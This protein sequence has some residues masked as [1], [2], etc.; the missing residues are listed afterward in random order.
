MGIAAIGLNLLLNSGLGAFRGHD[1]ECRCLDG[2][3]RGLRH[4][5]LVCLSKCTIVLFL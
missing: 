1:V 4:E 5:G 3:Y 2:A